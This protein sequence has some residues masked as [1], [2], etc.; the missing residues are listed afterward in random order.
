[1]KTALPAALLADQT[2]PAATLRKTRDAPDNQFADALQGGEPAQARRPK[3]REGIAEGIG[4]LP[5]GRDD[6]REAVATS[7]PMAT[8]RLAS[9][10]ARL[11]ARVTTVDRA[12]GTAAIDLEDP[13]DAADVPVG[14]AAIAPSISPEALRPRDPAVFDGNIA[15]NGEDEAPARPRPVEVVT[16]RPEPSAQPSH[17]PAAA[18]DART[19]A[20]VMGD[21][22]RAPDTH[23]PPPAR[24]VETAP[25]RA[26]PAAI[27]SVAGVTPV[28]SPARGPLAISA[29]ASTVHADTDQPAAADRRPAADPTPVDRSGATRTADMAATLTS[30]AAPATTAPARTLRHGEGTASPSRPT[31]AAPTASDGI[32]QRTSQA[33][34]VPVATTTQFATTLAAAVEMVPE[35]SRPETPATVERPGLL[36]SISIRLQPLELG[37]VTAHLR[38]DGQQLQVEVRVE[39]QQALERLSVERD[40]ITRALR[41]LGFEVEQVVIQ[42]SQSQSQATARDAAGADPWSGQAARQEREGLAGS[43]PG[44]RDQGGQERQGAGGRE[45]IAHASEMDRTSA[46]RPRAAGLYI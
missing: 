32:A 33:T 39:T 6:R 5:N 41:G 12:D 30:G 43:G 10:L 36:R 28:V 37:M 26:T 45:G 2:A 18:A 3:D 7:A 23:Q 34:A 14:E 31:V 4:T 20:Q 29:L 24:T 25:A 17:R 35:T 15:A 19:T 13:M 46:G 38:L 27:L 11:E 8:G 16:A 22:P 9:W 1:V 21:I 44:S 40:T 42:T